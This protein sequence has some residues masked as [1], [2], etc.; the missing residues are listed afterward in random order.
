MT[1]G[2][3]PVTAKALI[4]GETPFVVKGS[5]HRGERV[6]TFDLTP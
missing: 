1:N 6:F 2:P 5:V 4:G 3:D